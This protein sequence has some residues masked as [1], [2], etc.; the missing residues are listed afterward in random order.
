[1]PAPCPALPGSV[2]AGWSLGRGWGTRVEEA[3]FLP[4]RSSHAGENDR[5]PSGYLGGVR[6]LPP[7]KA[8][9]THLWVTPPTPVP[10]TSPPRPP[11][12]AH[13]PPLLAPPLLP[14]PPIPQQGGTQDVVLSD[15][16][17]VTP[18]DPHPS[19]QS[20][21]CRLSSRSDLPSCGRSRP[22]LP[23]SCVCLLGVLL[24]LSQHTRTHRL[25][26]RR[27]HWARANTV[28]SPPRR[29]QV[30]AADVGVR[31]PLK[32]PALRFMPCKPAF[33]EPP[34]ASPGPLPW[35]SP[36]LAPLPGTSPLRSTPR[37][38]PLAGCVP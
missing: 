14:D 24:L 38:R 37:H 25:F 28:P 8:F 32:G 23:H 2:A 4:A 3:S 20:V 30:S 36:S 26:L 18:A 15:P 6:A 31:L 7:P 5:C 22:P 11:P 13:W 16:T 34:M 17:S 29:S 35:R 27:C 19:P 1:M 33:S 12:M 21:K 10:P 9:P